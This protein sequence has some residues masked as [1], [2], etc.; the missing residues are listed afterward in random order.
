MEQLRKNSLSLAIWSI[1]IPAAFTILALFS[2]SVFLPNSMIGNI[3]LFVTFLSCTE[4]PLAVFYFIFWFSFL[5]SLKDAYK[6]NNTMQII[7]T[8]GIVSTALKIACIT[9]GMFG[10]LIIAFADTRYSGTINATGTGILPTGGV[11]N[12]VHGLMYASMLLSAIMFL[13]FRELSEP[14]SEMRIITLLLVILIPVWGIADTNLKSPVWAIIQI[15]IVI[16]EFYF[17]WKI[18]KGFKF[19]GK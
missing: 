1:I 12:V 18:Y 3:K 11:E 8:I 14:K 10:S 9:I 15:F 19:T 4:I 7:K 2:L 16:L 17:F 13:L 5:D 6:D